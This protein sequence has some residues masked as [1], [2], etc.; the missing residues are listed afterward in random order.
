MRIG[1]ARNRRSVGRDPCSELATPLH[2]RGGSARQDAK[3]SAHFVMSAAV[4]PDEHEQEASGLLADLRQDLRRRPADTQHWQNSKT[5]AALPTGVVV[6]L[7]RD[8]QRELTYTLSHVVRFKIANSRQYEA[9]RRALP[10][11]DC[12]IEWSALDPSGGRI[13]QR[14]PV[15]PLSFG[16]RRPA[17]RLQ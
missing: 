7:A 8:Q 1:A 13:D 5:S 16:G 3:S 10:Y 12:R 9:A 4:V 15:G 11:P 2:R 17:Y 6:R 14:N